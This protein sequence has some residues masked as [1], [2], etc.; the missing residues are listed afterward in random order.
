MVFT[1]RATY[2][3]G[4][5][6][7]AAEDVSAIISMISPHETPVLDRLSQAPKEATNVL[8]EWLEDELNPNTIVSSDTAGSAVT[9]ATVADLSGGAVTGF[10]QVGA[11]LTSN[12]TGEYLQ[13]SAIT[14]NILTLLRGFG[15]TTAATITAGDNL[16]I[17]SDAAIE[18]ADVTGDISRPRGRKTNFTQIFKKDLIIS[19]TVEATT[20]LGGVTNEMDYQRTQRLRESLRDL[21][22]A[23]IRG[24]TSG[25]S[26]GSPSAYRTMDGILARLTTNVT[27]LGSVG[28]LDTAALN[29]IIE[30]A[31]DQGGTDLDLIVADSQFKKQIDT[32]NSSRIDV[33]N[34]DGRVFNKTTVFEGTF[35]EHEVILGR[36]M[37]RNSLMVIS[38]QRCNVTPLQG[39][40]YRFTPV[41]RTGD[42]EKGMILGEYTV[43]VHNEEGMA[44]AYV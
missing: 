18:G 2:D 4:V 14:G 37:P 17:I 33:A 31:W 16:F 19:G 12:A 9:T 24:R 29:T 21:E 30:G 1:G 43:E 26:I 5:F 28:A 8:H 44:Q 11:I 20:Q 22:K 41:S 35:G 25:N 32:F 36:W 13:I 3:T 7:G 10:L 38:T 6:A 42:A 23:T 27:T 34:R 39:R 15:G 40:S